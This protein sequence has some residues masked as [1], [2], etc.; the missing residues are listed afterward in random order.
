MRKDAGGSGKKNERLGIHPILQRPPKE[1]LAK[2]CTR[3][4]AGSLAETRNPQKTTPFILICCGSVI[5]RLT[6]SFCV[7]FLPAYAEDSLFQNPDRLTESVPIAILLLQS[8]DN[9][10]H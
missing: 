8:A 4:A 9:S 1:S 3:N 10:I 7:I 5:A 2:I 6:L